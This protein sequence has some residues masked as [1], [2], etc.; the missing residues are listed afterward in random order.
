MGLVDY[1]GNQVFAYLDRCDRSNGA[2]IHLA[3]CLIKNI[4]L[5]QTMDGQGGLKINMKINCKGSELKED[6]KQ[7]PKWPNWISQ[8]QIVAQTVH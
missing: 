7:H 8:V 5:I 2:S 6:S 1:V 4:G 3:K